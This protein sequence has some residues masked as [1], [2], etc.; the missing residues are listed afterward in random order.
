M[1]SFP[2]VTPLR[3]EKVQLSDILTCYPSRSL[4][5]L[6]SDILHQT[7]ALSHLFR[8]LFTLLMLG[9]CVRNQN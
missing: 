4:L 7:S 8:V 3:V 6:T 1:F 9:R 2:K 5:P